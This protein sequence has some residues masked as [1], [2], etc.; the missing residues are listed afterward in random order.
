MI[1]KEFKC[2]FVKCD[3]EFV[4]FGGKLKQFTRIGSSS[5][6]LPRNNTQSHSIKL[7]LMGNV[8]V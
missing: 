1:T 3:W 4:Q 5:L 6:L 8:K 2:F 7:V